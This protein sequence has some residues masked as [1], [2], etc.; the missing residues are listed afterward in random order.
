MENIQ[1][2]T[3]TELNDKAEVYKSEAAES[4]MRNFILSI[5][6]ELDK[7]ARK[8]A[9]STQLSG[10]LPL[11]VILKLREAGYKAETGRKFI[12]DGDCGYFASVTNISWS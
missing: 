3:P 9:I 8:G 7:A 6:E 10:H 1:F 5:N 2:L 4:R 11:D 12:D